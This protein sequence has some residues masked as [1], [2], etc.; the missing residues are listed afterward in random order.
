MTLDGILVETHGR[1][2]M[3][4]RRAHRISALHQPSCFPSVLPSLEPWGADGPTPSKK[5]E[6]LEPL[7]NR[8]F[9]PPTR[10]VASPFPISLVPTLW[11]EF[12]TTNLDI[13]G[14]LLQ[15]ARRF[16]GFLSVGLPDNPHLTYHSEIVL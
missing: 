10:P 14:T 15:V 7:A 6:L 9:P 3:F 1:L 2:S 8:G 5:E 16:L 11:S 4:H 12:L 13:V